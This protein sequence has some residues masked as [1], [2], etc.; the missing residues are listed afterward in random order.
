MGSCPH[1]GKSK[2][3][4]T[5]NCAPRMADGRIFTDYR[6][7]C[8]VQYA[9]T[10]KEGNAGSYALRQFMIKNADN[11][12]KNNQSFAEKQSHCECFPKN[13]NGTQ[14]PVSQVQ[15]CN[16]KTC[17]ISRADP[18]GVGLARD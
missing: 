11:L 17:T 14:L 5:T 10:N 13:S 4:T 18:K 6:P 2:S 7:R 12:M 9:L 1:C 8:T 3:T 15:K 16:K